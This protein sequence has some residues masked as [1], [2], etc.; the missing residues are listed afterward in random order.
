MRE[1]ARR[2]RVARKSRR[3]GSS[4][5]PRSTNTPIRRASSTR[6]SRATRISRCIKTAGIP[7]RVHHQARA[8]TRRHP[9][10]QVHGAAEGGERRSRP[11]CGPDRPTFRSA[12]SPGRPTSGTGSA[13][14]TSA[15][16]FKAYWDLLATNPGSAKEAT[17]RPRPRKKRRRTVTRSRRSRRPPALADD[18]QG[19][20]RRLQPARRARACWTST[21]TSSTRPT[22]ARLHHARLRGQRA[23]QE[24]SSRTT[25]PQSH[26]I[27]L[28]LEK[29][30][31]PSEEQP[32]SRSS[33]STRRTTSTRRGARLSRTPVYQW[34]RE[35]NARILG[36][37]TH[38]SY[39]HSKFLLRDPL[40]A[41]PIVVT[42]SANF[43]EASTNGER[44]EHAGHS[45]QHARGRHLL[46][47]LRAHWRKLRT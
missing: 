37:N 42:G 30:D 32:R 41:D 38:V 16:R 18:S 40:G 22:V 11:R 46:H 8:A 26:L 15:A 21:S 13:T 4:S 24:H 7:R 12:A 14:A 34:A 35:T 29:K 3:C 28:L 23:L 27:F 17:A 43:S 33:S 2:P 31:K 20:P 19:R 45:R 9:A 25:P 5:T 39:I 10:Q 1:G 6:A 44:R 47:R 36:L